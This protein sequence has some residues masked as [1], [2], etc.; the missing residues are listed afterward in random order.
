VNALVSI[1]H[2]ALFIM[3]PLLFAALGGLFTESAGMLNI[4]LEG[5]MLTGSFFAALAAGGAGSAGAGVAAAVLSSTLLA[6]MFAAACL[7]LRANLFIAGIA[8]NLMA[9]GLTALLS[10]LLFGHKG[11]HR[12]PLFPALWKARPPAWS[13][14]FGAVFLSHDA[15]VY[16]AWAAVPLVV[17][18]LYKTPFGLRLRSTGHDSR[19]VR[20]LGME[21]NRYRLFAFLLSGVGCG[22]AGAFLSLHLQAFVPGGTAGRGWIALVV[23]YLGARRPGGILLAAFL[24]GL[25]E[26]VSNHLQGVLALPNQLI[27]AIPFAVSLLALIGYSAWEHYRRPT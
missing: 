3:A 24:F 9:A 7:K 5:L 23:I 4:G 20:S 26:S 21:P 10:G 12:F 15:L 25:A 16:A 2:N 27:L 22:L 14:A 17:L 6:L 8:T 11:V 1:L 13:G 19:T 18:I